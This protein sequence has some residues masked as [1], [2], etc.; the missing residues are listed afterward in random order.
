MKIFK[1]LL[2]IT[3]ICFCI[4]SMVACSEKPSNPPN[5]F[6]EIYSEYYDAEA[7][8]MDW[9]IL[10]PDKKT[11]TF[12]SNPNDKLSI[13]DFTYLD[14][15]DIVIKAICN[16]FN[17]PSYIYE[18]ISKTAPAD[19]VREYENEKISMKWYYN[20]DEGMKVVFALK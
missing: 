6:E 5:R 16:E 12:D 18:Q 7:N 20:Y 8:L 19:G 4:N 2:C 13:A 1:S 9:M 10:S 3:L 17:I 14:K 15:M 11:L